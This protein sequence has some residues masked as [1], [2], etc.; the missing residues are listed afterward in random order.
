MQ[1]VHEVG[2]HNCRTPR[3][4]CLTD[5]TNVFSVTK[6]CT[7]GWDSNAFDS[8]FLCMSITKL[9]VTFFDFRKFIYWIKDSVHWYMEFKT[10]LENSSSFFINRDTIRL[11]FT[12]LTDHSFRS[13]NLALSF[14]NPQDINKKCVLLFLKILNSTLFI[15]KQWLNYACRQ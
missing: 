3:S 7:I 14:R 10:N 5:I 6:K 8:A 11:S 4:S 1:L 15:L 13:I 9:Q 2:N 12:K